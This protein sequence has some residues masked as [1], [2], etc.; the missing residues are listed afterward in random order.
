VHGL[1]WSADGDEIAIAV[2]DGRYTFAA[3][4]S[5]ATQSPASEFCWPNEPC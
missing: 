3:D 1:A 4:G 2:D 5:G